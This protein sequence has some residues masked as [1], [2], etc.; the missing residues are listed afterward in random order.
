M[1]HDEALHK[2]WQTFHDEHHKDTTPRQLRHA[3][4]KLTVRLTKPQ[5]ER[6]HAEIIQ[7]ENASFTHFC[8][9]LMLLPEGSAAETL[10]NWLDETGFDT[11]DEIHIPP[12]DDGWAASWKVL[13]SGMAA[14]VASRTC[15]A[16]MDRMKVML[17]ASPK[18]THSSVSG[19]FR[20]I[21]H[22]GHGLL[23]FWRGNGV[24]C[25]KIGPEVRP[26]S[27]AFACGYVQW[28]ARDMFVCSWVCA[29]RVQR[30]V[31]LRA[32]V[33]VG[34]C[35]GVLCVWC[36]PP[37]VTDRASLLGVRER[38]ACAVCEP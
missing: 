24:N 2:V 9:L 15:T 13:V 36:C 26:A 10:M 25:L 18:P 7:D 32:S 22:E 3:L 12:V 1:L 38:K 6:L 33:C 8:S 23:A 34:V 14:G 37:H 28:R 19:V 16:P 30:L 17:Q 11:G 5:A 31:R 27:I 20:H 35:V 4:R 21:Y 29:S